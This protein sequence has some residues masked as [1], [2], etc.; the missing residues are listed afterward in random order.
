MKGKDHMRVSVIWGMTVSAI[1]AFSCASV[2]AFERG[3]ARFNFRVVD[4]A[5]NPVQ[6]ARIRGGAWWPTETKA[7]LS[8]IW[9]K[10]EFDTL[11]SPDGKAT[12]DVTAYVDVRFNVTK[13]G[14][15]RH[16][17]TYDLLSSGDNQMSLVSGRW[18]PW[19]ANKGVVLK[20][21]KNPVPMYAKRVD[22]L[23]PVQDA[24]IGFDLEAGDWVA[25]HGRGT[26]ADLELIVSGRYEDNMH[27]DVQMTVR[28]P[29]PKAGIVTD[30]VPVY[31][32]IPVG[33][34]LVSM[35]EAPAEGYLSSYSYAHRMRPAL[36]D[37]VNVTPRRGQIAY[38]RV[39]TVL[40]D[41]GEI[42]QAWYGKVYGDLYC[43]FD[44]DKRI[45]I[46]F[47][48]YLNP[49]GTRNVEFEPSRNLL[50][51]LRSLEQV[52]RP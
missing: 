27:R 34:T 50:V 26:V 31:K 16:E 19:P 28:F 4:D 13:E 17:G 40:D 12:V 1:M 33:S 35:H 29:S 20:R 47:T 38:F 6:N 22:A 42:E 9:N 24:S 30:Q 46:R 45:R 21:V 49:D 14:Y 8:S 48:Y 39:R 3:D 52:D 15:Y 41:T 36:S 43:T 25:P 37:R 10:K 7:F 44:S 32:E 5:N 51:G 11:T 23:V 18:Q 2:S